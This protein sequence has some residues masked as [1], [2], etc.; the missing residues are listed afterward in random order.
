MSAGDHLERADITAVEEH[1]LRCGGTGTGEAAVVLPEANQVTR[2]TEHERCCIAETQH[3]E[4]ERLTNGIFF[5]KVG[6]YVAV[7]R[8]LHHR[9]RRGKGAEVKVGRGTPEAVFDVLTQNT[10]RMERLGFLVG[11]ELISLHN[12]RGCSRE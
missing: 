9:D 7:G 12:R 1:S 11:G 3:R 4:S 5:L 6:L 10:E 8:R 2:N